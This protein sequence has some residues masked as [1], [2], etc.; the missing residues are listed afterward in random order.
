MGVQRSEPPLCEAENFSSSLWGNYV[1]AKKQRARQ[2]AADGDTEGACWGGGHGKPGGHMQPII[3][4][5]T[6]AVSATSGFHNPL[7]KL[8]FPFRSSL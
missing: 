2:E 3:P 7:P 6:E 1:V 5:K 4:T 8:L